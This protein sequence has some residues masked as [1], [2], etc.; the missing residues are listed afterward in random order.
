MSDQDA[1]D[2]AYRIIEEY[3]RIFAKLDELSYEQYKKSREVVKEDE[4]DE[5]I[6]KIEE[7]KNLTPEKI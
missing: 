5:E 6:R 2:I 3:V 7:K 1:L 4:E